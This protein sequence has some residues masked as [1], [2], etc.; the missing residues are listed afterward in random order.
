M[1]TETASK[2]YYDKV[3]DSIVECR[4]LHKTK[5]GQIWTDRWGRGRPSQGLVDSIKEAQ[6]RRIEALNDKIGRIEE[7][8]EYATTSI[9]SYE[10]EEK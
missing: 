8:M 2:Y 1:K 7:M 4:F 3:S 10:E 6:E 5:R 9:W